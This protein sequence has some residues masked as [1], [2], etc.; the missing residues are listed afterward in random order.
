MKRMEK[1]RATLTRKF[2]YVRITSE[3]LIVYEKPKNDFGGHRL[4][5]GRSEPLSIYKIVLYTQYQRYLLVV[6]KP[7]LL[8][9]TV[10]HIHCSTSCSSF[11][12]I[13]LPARVHSIHQVW[14]RNTMLSRTIKL[15]CPYQIGT[16]PRFVM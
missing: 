3:T 9:N 13:S 1:L 10:E 14:V 2:M 11:S 12:N 5:N 7:F 16:V 4:L 6:L 15:L 8:F